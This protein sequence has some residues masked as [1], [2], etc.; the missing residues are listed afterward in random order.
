M[1]KKKFFN[2]RDLILA[3]LFVAL[4]IVFARMFSIPVSEG[5]RLS[6]GD[7]PIIMAGLLLGPVWGMLVGALAD[8][9]GFLIAPMGAYIPGLTLTSALIGL[10]PGL[11]RKYVFK[12]S[13]VPAVILA[14]VIDM[15]LVNGLLKTWFLALVFSKRTFKAWFLARIPVEG[16]MV[17]IQSVVCTLLSTALLKTVYRPASPEKTVAAAEATAEK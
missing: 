6:F 8:G 3:S 11:I 7:T 4:S 5:L 9:V 15:L 16:A 10:I 2:T 1:Q 12:K 13:I 14:V 17:I